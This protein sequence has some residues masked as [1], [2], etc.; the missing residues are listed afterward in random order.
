MRGGTAKLLSLFRPA[1]GEYRALGVQQTTNALFHPWLKR[2]LAAV[3][4]ALS[5][6]PAAT[7]PEH[8]WAFWLGYEPRTPLPPLQL[9]LIGDNL[10]GQ[11]TPDVVVWL[12][13]H[14][15]PPLYTP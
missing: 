2:E 9:I 15:I 10:A 13:A 4:A 5:A 14:G 3:L 6:R 1:S 11:Y 12:F 8:A 7:R